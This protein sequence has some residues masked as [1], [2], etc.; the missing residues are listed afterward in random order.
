[1]QSAR[2]ITRQQAA[3]LAELFY[4]RVQQNPD[5]VA[6]REFNKEGGEWESHTWASMGRR[7]ARWRRVLQQH[8]LQAGERVALMLRNSTAWVV[9]DQAALSL[10]LVTVP[11]YMDDRADNIAYILR[12]AGVSLLLLENQRQLNKLHDTEDWPQEV[13]ILRLDQ[14]DEWLPEDD[15]A[16]WRPH[17][18]AADDLASIVYTSGTTGRSKGVMLSHRNLFSNV[19]SALDFLTISSED[20]LLSFLPLSHTLERT[21]GYYLPLAI[22]ATVAYARSVQQLATDLQSIRPSILIS[23][24]RIYEQVYNKI[25]HQLARQSGLARALFHL[26]LKIGWRRF[27]Y[28]QGRAGWHPGL[29]LWPL[30]NAKVARP[31]LAKLGGQLRVAICGGAPLPPDVGRL[32]IAL[33]LPLLQGYGLTEHSPII[34][35][36]HP[37]DNIPDSI[38]LSLPRI[39][40][41]LGENDELQ[42]RSESVMQGYWQNAEATA[43]V[44]DGDGWLHTGDIA[45]REEN[46]HW[47]ITGRLK[48]IIVMSNGEKVPPGDMEMAIGIDPWFE[49]IMVI[50]EGKA[51]LAMLA[52]LDREAWEGL[53]KELQLAADDPVSLRDK[54]V[55][56]AVLHRAKQHLKAFPG[57]AQIRRAH[58]S[59]TP[60]TVESGFMTPTLKL[61][62][63][64]ILRHHAEDIERLY[65]QL[66]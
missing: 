2:R 1:M 4:Q 10:G 20:S 64:Q 60:W 65:Q 51:F 26:A 33:G 24:P 59:L 39:E 12:E 8:G 13:Q 9:F 56:K 22:G 35:A 28:Q 6:Y 52:V 58:V 17:P 50:G 34:A 23:V 54:R 37:D 7:V 40:T 48:D 43:A 46:G 57:Y 31:I 44:L 14:A 42:V 63:P 53:A 25:Q 49:Q 47:F 55:E 18:G 19:D 41:R 38:G 5:Q 3:T 36:N 27:E 15:G 32:F 61:K 11:L 29:L 21:V 66:S 62:R 16:D 30:L 45:R